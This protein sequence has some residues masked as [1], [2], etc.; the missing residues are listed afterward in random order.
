[1][2]QHKKQDNLRAI[3]DQEIER[4]QQQ[5][6]NPFTITDPSELKRLLKAIYR[7]GATGTSRS[8]SKDVQAITE[9]L[10]KEQQ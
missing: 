3:S 5:D 4:T 6:S 1:M 9:L 7:A 8:L 2:S 10:T